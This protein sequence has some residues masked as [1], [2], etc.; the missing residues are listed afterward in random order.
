MGSWRFSPQGRGNNGAEHTNA[1]PD[2]TGLP[3]MWPLRPPNS[4]PPWLD[5]ETHHKSERRRLKPQ[6][7]DSK[8]GPQET[9]RTRNVARPRAAE[10][11]NWHSPR[12]A[13][14]Q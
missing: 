10:K 6:G 8:A 7:T 5:T 11:E 4:P 12:A 9:P 3:H 2:G 13:E 14:K 1:S